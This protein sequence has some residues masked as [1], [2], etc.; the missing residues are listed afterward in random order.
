MTTRYID[1]SEC[2][3]HS[4][5][6]LL[7]ICL[8]SG[9]VSAD[10]TSATDGSTPLGLQPGAPAGSY[11]LSDFDTI[12]LYNGNLSFQL[13]LLGISGRGRAQM[14]VLL[15]IEGKWRVLDLTIPQ[16]DG[17]VK[18][19]Y[20][21]MQSWWENNDRKYRP[22]SLVARQGSV[23]VME[24]PDNTT[25]YAVTLT[26]LTFIG[27]DGTEYELRDQLTGG[28]PQSNGQCNYSNPPSRGKVFV[29]S[30][31]SAATFISDTPIQDYV[32]APNSSAETYPSGYL[33]LRDGTRFRIEGGH[34][35]WMRDRNGNKL[36]FG[37]D[38]NNRVAT[39]IDS[40]NRVVTISRNTGPGTFDQITYQGFGGATRT[41]KV[42]YSSM[43]DA[44][45]SDYPS[46]LTYKALFPEL[47]GSSTGYHN[48][49]VVSSIT[50]PNNQQYLIRYN[51]YGE[52]AR[53]V[54]PTGGA[55]EYD[56]G[57]GAGDYPSGSW[58]GF[59]GSWAI[60]RRVV[61]RRVYPDGATGSAYAMRMT[62][63]STEAEC[64][65]C[66]KVDQFNN[67]GTLLTRS[68][69]YF[70]GSAAA[71]FLI[72]PTDYPAW[73]EDKEFQTEEFASDGTT[74]LRRIVNTWQQPT[75]GNTWPLTQ[76]ET[77]DLVKSNNP[78]I[79]QTVTTLE[80]SQAN[81]VS[82]QTFAYDKYTNKTDVYEYDF[83][84]GAAGGLV[85]RTHSDYLTSSY[86]TLN[87]NSSSPDLNLTSHIRSLPTQ[88]S[89]FDSGG[90]ERARSTTEYDNYVLDGSDCAHSFHCPLQSRANISGF[91]SLFTASYTLRGNPTASTRYLLTN[92]AVTGSVSSYTHYDVA[93]NVVRSIDPRS[94][95]PN[96]FVTTIEYD[97]RF[98][99]PDNDARANSAPAE[100]S[101]LTSFAF[102]TKVTNALGHTIYAQFDYYLGQPVNGE[103]ANGVVASGSFNDS[104]D[105]PTQ[106]HRAIGTSVEN[107]TTFAYDDTNHIITTSSDRDAYN[108]N[109]LVSKV[110]YDQIGRTKEA[111]Q[112]EGGDN[113][114]V[115]ETQYDA[116]GRPF[117]TSNPYRLWQSETAVWTMQVFDALGRVTSVTTPDSSVVNTSYSGNTVTVTDQAGK[118][119]K[120]VTDA[121]GRLS[122]VFEDP[123]P[124][125]NYQTTYGYDVLDDLTTVTQGAQTRT[126]VYDSLKRL[127]SA[128]NP[129]NGTISY[130]YDNNS[131]LKQRTDG[132]GIVS[133][134]EYDALNRNT[135][136]DYSDTTS[137]N[138]DVSRFYDGATNGKGKLWYS[139]AGGNESVGSNVEKTLFDSY[140]ALGRPLVLRQL[141][142]L[143]GTWS[144]A[145]QVSRSYNRA[146][147]V[148]SQTYPSGH[149]VTYNYDAAGRLADN[150]ANLAFTG[151]LGDGVLR[152]YARGTSYISSGAMKQEQFGT[153]TPVYNK[154][155]YN[156]RL[157]LAEI[158][159]STTGGDSSWN[160]GKIINDYSLQCS[161]AACNATDN[162]GNL[163]KQE[164][165]IPAN[166]QVSSYT[167]WYQQY[168]YDAL[169]RLKR[170]QEYTPSLAW[171]QEYDY[172]QWGNRTINQVNTWGNNIPKPNFGV[173]T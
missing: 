36:T 91:D 6:I 124:G 116:L 5:I 99:A 32:I 9:K 98:G 170:V 127:K 166:D 138:P 142:K 160:R 152:T 50:L 137:I 52:V 88:V 135:T 35:E 64:A 110:V 80:P 90:V 163:R 165:Y 75:A 74:L 13:A 7:F 97:D 158:L 155:F 151:N 112:Y 103:D 56:Y 107:Q 104:L 1:A 101:G 27:P 8:M 19:V 46:T 109:V 94:T 66:V 123:T 3:L 136:I 130:D 47:N 29:T 84:A 113:Y 172:D 26:R 111:R 33:M 145:Y 12:N 147:S 164:V 55:V 132:R 67:S 77:N 106:I 144:S 89:I 105:R 131:N 153:T 10:T 79:T 96:F 22:G 72:G 125:L 141:F 54:L 71:S 82:K 18:H 129:E 16:I 23:E 139:Y 73:K 11:P 58:A 154:L 41:V 169:N 49:S 65:G 118:K 34:V 173:N 161:G 143:N 69:H 171:Q 120:S 126:F 114:I 44:L 150:G 4:L 37:Y 42:N 53:V 61:E 128:T 59:E 40:L 100:L 148:T 68:K 86:D 48:P 102:P 168:D 28:Q 119:R 31:G 108:D 17:S 162:N 2:I 63:S 21:P 51:P 24:C 70:Y 149:T 122:N 60:Y 167:S 87:P 92:G 159:T 14:P 39:I 115:T 146:G 93:G 140:D 38:S 81:Q 43:A 62:Y 83:G 57:A 133:I 157:Q 85:R 156:S 134:Y 95:S 78:Q 45:R 25:V 117:K 15:P 30:D 20:L 76:P 121:L